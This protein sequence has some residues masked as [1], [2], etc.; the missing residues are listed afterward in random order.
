MAVVLTFNVV[1]LMW[2]FFR[3]QDFA[4]AQLMLSQMVTRFDW[5]VAV[6]AVVAYKYV[7]AMI[8]LAFV[9]HF[10]PSSWQQRMVKVLER[11]GIVGCALLIVAVVYLIIQVKTADVQPFIY[12][13][14]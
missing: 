9:A 7:F 10:M 4:S 8:L 14:F 2:V 11:G 5:Q 1:S 3:N 6:Q 13:Q 12:F